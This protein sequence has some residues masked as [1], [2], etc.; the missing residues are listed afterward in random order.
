MIMLATVAVLV[1]APAGAGVETSTG[2]QQEAWIMFNDFD[3]QLQTSRDGYLTVYS[4]RAV[5]TSGLA[6]APVIEYRATG[7][8][9]E[10][11]F[12]QNICSS[13]GFNWQTIDPTAFTTDPIGNSAEID[14]C[15][16]PTSNSSCLDFELT[17]TRPANLS[18]S[19]LCF[20]QIV[21]GVNAWHDPG[22]GESHAALSWTPGVTRS[23]YT[24]AG[25]FAGQPL[26]PMAN[27]FLDAQIWQR[28]VL[29]EQGDLP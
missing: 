12:Q 23:G 5:Q 24:V 1:A 16:L 21:C 17:M 26:P 15:L 27:G 18:P 2:I 10:C 7:Y 11:D 8:Y 6:G 9:S 28:L 19:F 29:D 3:Q 4:R 20:P 13:V 22:T 14:A 25:T